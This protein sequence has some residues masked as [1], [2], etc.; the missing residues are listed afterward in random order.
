[1]N[2]RFYDLETTGLSGGA[3]NI[4]F[5]IGL[6]WWTPQGLQVIQLFLAD[7]PGEPQL[8]ERYQELV[9]GEDAIQV[10]FNGKS[11]DSHVLQ[12]RF[13]LN[14]MVPFSRRELD[15]LHPSRRLWKE[16]LPRTDLQTLEREVLGV[17]RKDD[18]PGSEAP[19]AWFT[20]L[21][22]EDGPLEEVF[23]HNAQDIVSL[24]LLLTH[25][26]EWGCFMPSDDGL[27][28]QGMA[29]S[30]FGMARQWQ[31]VDEQWMRSWLEWGWKRGE[32]RCGQELGFF[33]KRQGQRQEAQQIWKEILATGLNFVA[34]VELAKDYEHRERNIPRAIEAL[35]G[36]EMLPLSPSHRQ[37]L[38]YRQARLLG[39][40]EKE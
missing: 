30:S 28:P 4:A 38:R 20:W 24:A 10:S 29:P 1:M 17:H 25:L 16:V 9:D 15:L 5:L 12:A 27:E 8:L 40:L 2:L 6:G 18:L 23:R 31:M 33:L 37:A 13:L 32:R 34:A 21:K 22:G 7:Y 36:L 26:Q 14:R 19:E 39:K 11:F 3:G 35:E